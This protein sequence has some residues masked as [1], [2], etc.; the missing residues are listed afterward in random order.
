MFKNL[1]TFK[2][3]VKITEKIIEQY[4]IPII[5]YKDIKIDKDPIALTGS[6]KFYKGT[7]KK[8]PCSIKVIDIT[9]SDTVKKEFSLWNQY[10]SNENF[11]NLFGACIKSDYAYLVFEFFAFTIEFALKQNLITE[12]NR[13]DLVKQC[14]YIISVLQNDEKKICDIRPGV[15]G[16][17]DQ[18]LVKLLDF[19]TCV[20]DPLFNNDEIFDRY[21]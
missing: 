1:F 15:F 20:N 13:S 9:K 17:T 11:L 18:V 12:D 5:S 21:I 8:A 10:K 2:G 7:Y 6:G 3:S 16:I 4:G 14:L 19:G